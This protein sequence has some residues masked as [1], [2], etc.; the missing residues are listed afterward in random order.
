MSQVNLRDASIFETG[1]RIRGETFT[2]NKRRGKERY[3]LRV[4]VKS[5]LLPRLLCGLKVYFTD[6]FVTLLSLLATDSGVCVVSSSSRPYRVGGDR[7][8]VS[9]REIN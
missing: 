9:G 5:Y 7:E 1:G 2:K 4:S 8:G 3:P 6:S